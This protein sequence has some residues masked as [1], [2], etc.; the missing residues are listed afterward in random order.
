[1]HTVLR[2]TSGAL[3]DEL[4]R[5]LKSQIGASAQLEIHIHNAPDDLKW[6]EEDDFWSIISSF[7]WSKPA[8]A[9]QVIADA[10]NKLSHLPIPAIY[11]F[12]EILAEKLWL[13]DTRIHAQAW[14][15]NRQ[16]H[17]FSVDG[18]LY[19]RCYVVATGRS[20]F[21]NVLNNPEHWPD[22]DGFE[23]LLRLASNAYS[24][25]TGQDFDFFPA[26]NYETYSNEQGWE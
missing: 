4:V 11:R 24:V 2:L 14:Q 6:F 16:Q 19:A 3:S 12:E 20:L 1:M 8:D 7:D 9:D 17:H 15:A 5:D 26:I 23:I 13:L 18:F 22:H 25:K 21:E 10:I